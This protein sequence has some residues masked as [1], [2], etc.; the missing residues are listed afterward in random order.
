MHR[1]SSVGSSR[2]ADLDLLA[3]GSVLQLKRAGSANSTV[4]RGI[5]KMDCFTCRMQS[6]PH[7]NYHFRHRS[8][9]AYMLCATLCLL[10]DVRQHSMHS[11]FEDKVQKRL[12]EHGMVTDCRIADVED[13]ASRFVVVRSLKSGGPWYQYARRRSK[14]TVDGSCSHGRLSAVGGVVAR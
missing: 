8:E 5:S 7:T 11:D 9:V 13:V 12:R 10:Y 4:C 1:C 6:K 3:S 2:K 14:S